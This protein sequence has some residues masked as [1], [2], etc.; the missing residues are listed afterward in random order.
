MSDIFHKHTLS[1]GRSVW[2]QRIKVPRVRKPFWSVVT[3]NGGLEAPDIVSVTDLNSGLKVLADLL[4][5][6][7]CETL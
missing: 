1:E 7:V 3:S 6:A 2:M 5:D 4:Q